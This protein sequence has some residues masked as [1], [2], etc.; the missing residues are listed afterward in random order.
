MCLDGMVRAGTRGKWEGKLMEKV[1]G[2]EGHRLMF[3]CIFLEICFQVQRFLAFSMVREKAQ[4]WEFPL[5]LCGLVLD[6]HGGLGRNWEATVARLGI[7]RLIG[8]GAAFPVP[9][10]MVGSMK[11]CCQLSRKACLC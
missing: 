5:A 10:G 6:P 4:C 1:E 11:P 8:S 9:G 3:S 2:G 7:G